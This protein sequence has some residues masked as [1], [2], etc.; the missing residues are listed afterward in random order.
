LILIS[1]ISNPKSSSAM[2]TTAVAYR[3]EQT[4]NLYVETR[5][6]GH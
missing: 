6:Q 3:R 1:I 2:P 5:R 4:F